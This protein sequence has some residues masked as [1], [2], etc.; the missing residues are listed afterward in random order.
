[1]SHHGRSA[2]PR[3][4]LA[5]LATTVAAAA[6]VAA[7]SSSA[8]TP[9]PSAA[10]ST[11]GGSPA[12]CPDLAT[13]LAAANAAPQWLAT[14]VVPFTPHTSESAATANAS[15]ALAFSHIAPDQ[16][17]LNATFSGLSAGGLSSLSMISKT[18]DFFTSAFGSQ[19]W[20][21]AVVPEGTP[22]VTDPVL[23]ALADAGLVPTTSAPS[24]DLP[25]T[26]SCVLAFEAMT[27]TPARVL[28]VTSYPTSEVQYVVMRVDPA[29]ALPQSIAFFADPAAVEKGDPEKVVL[30]IDYVSSVSIPI[31]DAAFLVEVGS[32]DAP[33]PNAPPTLPAFPLP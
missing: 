9:A 6:L 20:L 11:G 13:I 3:S 24:V 21:H 31:P 12:S 33:V 18:Q 14:G 16:G 19:A 4:R 7:C 25:G 27:P 10:P 26:A 1:M 8:S 30:T 28:T 22:P 15:A 32:P 5:G 2:R 23:V 29:T 17:A